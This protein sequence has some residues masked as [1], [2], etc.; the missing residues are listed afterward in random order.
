M[1][2]IIVEPLSAQ[3]RSQSQFNPALH[4]LC[5]VNANGH[6]SLPRQ[7]SQRTFGINVANNH[8]IQLSD[9]QYHKGVLHSF[10]VTL[11]DYSSSDGITLYRRKGST[12]LRLSTFL[13]TENL[14]YGQY[15][16]SL[17]GEPLQAMKSLRLTIVGSHLRKV[18]LDQVEV[19]RK[20]MQA[21]LDDYYA[22]RKKQLDK[23]NTLS[24][25]RHF[26]EI[27]HQFILKVSQLM[28]LK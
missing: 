13:R 7:L 19:E 6:V 15:M 17:M 21:L 3:E 28:T 12:Q 24:R 27:H 5:Q 9:L 11:T 10:V 1:K 20:Q 22:W 2:S 16:F 14:D 25:E 8:P 4:G 23:S 26:A 18:N